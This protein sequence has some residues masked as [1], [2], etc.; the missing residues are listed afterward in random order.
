[1]SRPNAGR[2]EIGL[3]ARPLAHLTVR[4]VKSI[5][6]KLLLLACAL[7]LSGAHWV[8]LQVTAWT[9][10]LVVRSQTE[11][12]AEAV[13]TTFD[14]EHPCVMCSAI[15]SGQKEEKRNDMD[16]PMMKA[17]MEVKLVAMENAVLPA[18]FATGKMHWMKFSPMASLRTDAPPT[19]PPLA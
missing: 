3:D 17:L 4:P 13:K 9:G 12:V 8:V 10:M 19:P 18:P 6:H 11:G 5:F 16:A 14:G 15:E 1:M 7:H 2:G